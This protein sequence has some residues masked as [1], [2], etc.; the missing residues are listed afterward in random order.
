[1]C[2]RACGWMDGCNKANIPLS[3]HQSRNNHPPIN[4]PY[5]HVRPTTIHH[6]VD[7]ALLPLAY[8]PTVRTFADHLHIDTCDVIRACMRA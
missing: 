5:H 3:H 2:V 4:H 1:M 7:D 6:Q 8:N